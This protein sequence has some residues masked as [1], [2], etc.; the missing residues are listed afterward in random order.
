MQRHQQ[1]AFLARMAKPVSRILIVAGP[2]QVGKTFM[3]RSS[4]AERSGPWDYW[5]A[6]DPQSGPYDPN[7]V[8][9]P[10]LVS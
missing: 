2:R 4:L 1:P 3:V 7:G 5:D 6:D 10:R 9:V 8:L